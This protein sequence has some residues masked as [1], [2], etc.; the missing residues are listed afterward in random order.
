MS[1]YTDLEIP[2]APPAPNIPPPQEKKGCAR[3]AAIG[4]GGAILLAGLFGAAVVFFVFTLMKSSE[5]Y[6]ETMRRAQ[7]DIRV[8]AKL[9]SP[10]KPGW[11]MTGEINTSGSSGHANLSIPLEGP[12]GKATAYV[13]ADKVAGKWKYVQMRATFEDGSTVDLVGAQGAEQSY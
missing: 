10:I 8:T 1:Q 4:C 7:Q 13:E 9:G 5:P 2:P 3:Y 11:F 6:K 12:K